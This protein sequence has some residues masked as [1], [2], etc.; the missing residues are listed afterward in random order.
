MLMTKCFIALQVHLRSRS[1]II[2]N[3]FRFGGGCA[4][5]AQMKQR[6][7]VV[8]QENDSRDSSLQFGSVADIPRFPFESF[9]QLQAAVAIRSFTIGVDALAAAEWAHKFNTKLNRFVISTLSLLLVAA[10]L[11]AIAVAFITREYLLLAALPIVA[12]SFYVS[13]PASSI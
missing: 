5:L 10:S 9:E 7:A 4:S 12:V 1:G 8:I 3:R 13:H 11:A 6:P 2:E